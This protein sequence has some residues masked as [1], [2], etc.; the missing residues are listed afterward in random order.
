[1][2][3]VQPP[4]QCPT[5]NGDRVSVTAL[6]GG[7]PDVL[8]VWM[9]RHHISVPTTTRNVTLSRKV[10]AR[11]KTLRKARGLTQGHLAGA[12]TAAG[13]PTQWAL[14]EHRPQA[15]LTIDQTYVV[16]LTLGLSLQELVDSALREVCVTCSGAPPP[17]F[18]CNRCGTVTGP[19]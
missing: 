17:G 16:A 5:L 2:G 18:T 14:I 10:V 19:A 11:V 4:H 8:G 1:M 9:M 6:K 13:Y 12:L 7:L 3:V 15:A